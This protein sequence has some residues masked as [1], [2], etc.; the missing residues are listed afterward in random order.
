MHIRMRVSFKCQRLAYE[1][2]PRRGTPILFRVLDRLSRFPRP[3]QARRDNGLIKDNG[4]ELKI[5]AA[6]RTWRRN[7]RWYLF[8]L[9]GWGPRKTGKR[10]MVLAT[11]DVYNG[12]IPF[13]TSVWKPSAARDRVTNVIVVDATRDYE[14]RNRRTG[15]TTG[16]THGPFPRLRNYRNS[17][18]PRG[19]VRRYTFRIETCESDYLQKSLPSDTFFF[20]LQTGR[21]HWRLVNWSSLE[22]EIYIRGRTISVARKLN[23]LQKSLSFDIFFSLETGQNHWPLFEALL[24]LF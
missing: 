23:H 12:P 20:S 16:T 22:K 19:H 1:R 21:N 8:Y 2:F 7:F 5:F 6:S 11:L 17:P 18:P 13:G 14:R 9:D 3:S 15:R 10:I 4:T 24:K